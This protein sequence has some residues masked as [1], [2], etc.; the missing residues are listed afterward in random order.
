MRRFLAVA[1]FL[2]QG[3]CAM[4]EAH[5]PGTEWMM[6][7]GYRN[8]R[9]EHCCSPNK[10]CQVI[11]DSDLELTPAGWR[12]KPTGEI[13]AERDTFVSRDKEGRHWR[14]QGTIYWSGDKKRDTTRCLFVAPGTT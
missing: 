6:D 5:E 9:N 1:L 4:A 11:P 12:Y 8:S 3:I 7:G 13:I 10:D 14:C 2:L